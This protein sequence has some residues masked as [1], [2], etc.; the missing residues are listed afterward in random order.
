[1]NSYQA[2]IQKVEKLTE[3]WMQG[4]VEEVVRILG[5]PVEIQFP[6]TKASVMEGIAR[7]VLPLNWEWEVV[8]VVGGDCFLFL[9]RE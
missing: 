5:N 3:M 7:M 1:M 8:E 6:V 2:A 4:E 9:G